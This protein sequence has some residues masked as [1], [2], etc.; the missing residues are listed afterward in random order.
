MGLHP[1]FHPRA[2]L[3]KSRGC[4][5][6]YLR[7]GPQPHSLSSTVWFFPPER[8]ERRDPPAYATV[9]TMRRSRIR[10]RL[11]VLALTLALGSAA[12]AQEPRP[13]PAPGSA[14]RVTNEAGP[15]VFRL[16]AVR[17]DTLVAEREGIVFA[18]PV[19]QIERLEVRAARPWSERGRVT[20]VFGGGGLAAGALLG[21]AVGLAAVEDCQEALCELDTLDY[22][23]RGSL[24]GLGAGVAVGAIVA[25]TNRWTT[26]PANTLV[27]GL[28]PA[29]GGL[30]LELRLPF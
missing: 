5:S 13:A 19:D 16:R 15:R 9:C 21:L 12:A 14:I 2:M 29:G 11:S 22:A 6:S 27:V 20:L 25:F 28:R 24:I 3:R 26:V 30:E 7:G 18:F 4:A 8:A 23:V 10:L 17:G 1:T